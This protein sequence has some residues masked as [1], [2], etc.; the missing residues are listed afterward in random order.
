M[1]LEQASATISQ[2]AIAERIVDRV[3]DRL[4]ANRGVMKGIGEVLKTFADLHN[5]IYRRYPELDPY[6]DQP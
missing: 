4:G 2:I 3:C 6:G 1:S 5:A